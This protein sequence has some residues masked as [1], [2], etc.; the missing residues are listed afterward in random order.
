MIESFGRQ[1]NVERVV[2]L[3]RAGIVRFSSVPAQQNAE[4]E[5]GSPTCQ[6]CHKAPP[7]QRGS[8]RVI[9]TAGG[10]VL[11]TVVPFRNHERCHACHDP[12]RAASTAS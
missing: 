2:I 4:L 5:I 7:E 3:D 11:R 9:E 1:P 6:A 8:S 12:S 10:T